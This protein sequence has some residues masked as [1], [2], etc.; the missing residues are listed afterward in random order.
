MNY[1]NGK[2][3]SASPDN[4]GA[5]KLSSESYDVVIQSYRRATFLIAIFSCSMHFAEDYF[6]IIMFKR[7]YI[8]VHFKMTSKKAREQK[9]S[10]MY[11]ISQFLKEE[12]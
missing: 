10:L 3:V 11:L 4:N 12:G 8:F 6:C 1:R 5:K 7:T 2:A 9:R